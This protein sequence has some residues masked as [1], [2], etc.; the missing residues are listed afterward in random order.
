MCF[1][2]LMTP[3]L[4]GKGA[5]MNRALSKSRR[6]IGVAETIRVWECSDVNVQE[7]EK[8]HF[9]VRQRRL[10]RLSVMRASV[11]SPTY[12]GHGFW[13]MSKAGNAALLKSELSIGLL[14]AAD[15]RFGPK[16]D[17][18]IISEEVSFFL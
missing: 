18:G 16:A 2:G 7:H 1:H 12:S 10:G 4:V 11:P 14:R 17:I 3:Y 6:R 8:F 9:N 5:I 15:V 13:Q